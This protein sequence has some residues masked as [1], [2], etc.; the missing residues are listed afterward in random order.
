MAKVDGS[1]TATQAPIAIIGMGCLFPH[2]PSLR[3]Y[4]RLIRWSEDGVTDV[5]DTHWS[6]DDYYDAEANGRDLT[7][8][9]R[10][11][12][13]SP[14]DFDPMEFGIPP[15]TLEATDTAQLLG[16][17]VAKS[18]LEDAG[19]GSDREFDRGR[20]SVILGVT[21]TLE[22]VI[23]LGARMGHPHWRRAML[24]AGVPA[25][26]SESIIERIAEQYVP[27]QENSFPGLLGNVVAGRIANRLNLR[28]TNCVVD[29]ACASSLSAIHLSLLE[30]STGRTDMVVSGGVDALNDIFMFMCFSKT[31]ALS[32]TGDARP[33]SKDADGTVIGEGMGMIVLK[34]LADAERDGDRVYAVIRGVGTSSDGKSQSIYAPRSEGQAEALR[35]AYRISGIDPST[36]QLVEAHGTGTKVGDVV[37]FDALK[38]VYRES[39]AEGKWCGVGSVKSQIG[40]T[41]A[42][43][44]V[45]GIIKTALSLHH[46]VLPAMIKV[47]EANPNLDV[48]ASPFYLSTETR[49]WV[50]KRPATRRSSVSSFGFGGSNFHAVLEE[51]GDCKSEVSWDGTVT[52]IAFSADTKDGLTERLSEWRA[53]VGEKPKNAEIAFRARESRRGFRAA[54]EY[55]LLVVCESGDDLVKLLSGAADRLRST[56]EGTASWNLPSVFFGG[57]QARGKIAFL[58]PGQASQY[59]GMGRDLACMFPE[60]QDAVAQADGESGLC[61][62][63]YPHPV[64]DKGVR[65]EQ[66]ARLTHTEVAQPAIGAVSLACLRVLER[67]GV[68][69]DSVAGHSYGELVALR[70]A[71][72]IDDA[73]LR[74]LSSVRGRLMAEGSSE[75]GTMLAVRAPLNDIDA[76]LTE[77]ASDAVLAHRNGP[78]QGILSGSV[79]AIEAA[80]AASASRGWQT[81]RL[82]VSA[83]FHSRLMSAARDRFRTALDEASMS[84]GSIPVI[85][86]RTAEAYPESPDSVR[87]MLADQLVCPVDFVRLIENMRSSGVRL[88]V[89]VGPRNVLSGLVRSILGDGSQEAVSIDASCGRAS[90]VTDFA[91]V[92]ARL[93]AMGHAVDLAAWEPDVAEPRH[94]AMA[95]PLIGANY[96][97]PKKKTCVEPN[98]S[99]KAISASNNGKNYVSTTVENN[100]KKTAPHAMRATQPM[101]APTQTPAV[102]PGVMQV[103]QEGL[104]AMQALQQQTA[105]AHQ[106]FL[107]GQELAQQTFQKV[108]EHQ[109]RLVEHSLGMPVSAPENLPPIAQM[110]RYDTPVPAPAAVQAPIA[111][112]ATSGDNGE[113]RTLETAPK[114]EVSAVVAVSESVETVSAAQPSGSTELETTL[115]E[116]VAELTGY[117]IEML[118][119][120]MDLEADLGIDS[121]KRVEILASVQTRL[122]GL[123]AVNSS[124]MGSLRTL[125]N[126]IDYMASPEGETKTDSSPAP[127]VEVVAD[128]TPSTSVDRRVLRAVDLPAIGKGDGVR[129]APGREVWVLEDANGLAEAISDNL[130]ALG[131]LSRVVTSDAEVGH[132][133]DA[134]V[135]GLI[136]V[137]SPG[138]IWDE[139]SEKALKDAF[140]L[141]QRVGTLLRDAA[142]EGGSLFATVSRMDGAFGLVGGEFDPVQ[143]GLAG[144]AKTVS[145]EW[146]G[147]RTKALDVSAGWTDHAKAADAVVRELSVDGPIEVGLDS[148]ARRG[149]ALVSE[150]VSDAEWR[151]EAGQAIV[152]SGGARG[153]TAEVAHA[154]AMHNNP[155]LVLLGRSPSPEDEPA[156]L[157]DV[158][159]EAEIKRAIMAHGFDAAAKPT[160]VQLEEAYGRCVAD[161]EIRATVARLELAGAKVIYRSVDVRDA[162]AV[163]EVIAKARK[164]AGPIGSLIHG[165]GVIEDRWI[166]DKKAAQFERVFDTKVAG[167]RNLLD[168]IGDDNL[169]SLVLFSSVS[170]RFGRQG[171]VDYAMANEV[172][173]KVAHAQARLR[174]DCRVVSIN[175]G[176]WEGGMVTPGLRKEFARIGVGLVP[177]KEGA[178]SLVAELSQ[179][180]GDVEVMIGCELPSSEPMSQPAATELSPAFKRLLDIDRHPFLRSH[181]IGGHP[182]LPVAVILEWLGHGALHDNPGL[183]LHGFEDFRVLKGVVLTNGPADLRVTASKARRNG[184]L[185]EV[186]VELRGHASNGRE[187]PHA[188]ARAI[189]ATA[190]PAPPTFS[191]PEEIGCRTYARGVEGAY[192]EVLFHGPGFQGIE[193]VAGYSAEGM[194]AYVRS[195]AG[196]SDWMSEPVRSAWLGDPLVVDAGLQI[197]ILWCHEEL[198]AVSL[199]SSGAGYYQYRPSFPEI[200]VSA[201]LEIRSANETQMTADVTFL[202]EAGIVVAQ[203]RGFSWT[204]DASLQAAFGREA[205]AGAQSS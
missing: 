2:A 187:T 45:A 32:P 101:A 89:E 73:T 39:R 42:A 188:R 178:E 55:R 47:G 173:N 5:P 31:Q 191:P 11:A 114:A 152:I 182:V 75:P 148:R 18:A 91:R 54:D 181:V 63:I 146:A 113:H 132:N 94:P 100:G 162:A 176:P 157:K 76:M 163:A 68:R 29:A 106:R 27:W 174:P 103:V 153:V 205:V 117:P 175:W 14:V 38:T 201:V 21:G 28:G 195:A 193:R 79:A 180:G 49:P 202:D 44:G 159:E 133:G 149:L 52:I 126:I 30:L 158:S 8:C 199:P 99:C 87:D 69:A 12:F 184:S 50:G 116:V 17:K 121:I 144:L 51:Y 71:G 56:D 9:R 156:W 61:E 43:S 140:S 185:F 93:G 143:G 15:S 200:G 161:R 85:A 24:E 57:P 16:L 170:G 111:A 135:G 197:G 167:L 95:V 102:A 147:V 82:E 168:A 125:R 137:A 77:E 33:F 177:L 123:E 203:M 62:R 65:A 72:R 20:T 98:R 190:L 131:T 141:T 48:D 127:V 179:V 194:V 60:A 90:G 166:A 70:A 86:N 151:P 81:T 84:E 136:I 104:R 192:N 196:P 108:L 142:N 109:Q 186:D 189:L 198:G 66:Q 150:P 204:V 78:K 124:Y 74:H 10:G 41:K 112:A 129:I 19:Y 3:E 37:E 138:G 118:D 105:E 67:F 155:I 97:P 36:V 53:L 145:H 165:A 34:R 58:F 23:P 122:P 107:Q 25:D 83:A 183:L 22:L 46:K 59:V 139:N 88:F 64:F 1:V 92:L 6:I 119:P 13:L 154:L 80:D 130:M 7:Y 35:S 171:Q 172:L 164:I 128:N 26:V 96:R 40:H 160:P 110:P 120:D 169:K 4:W 134:A 115:L